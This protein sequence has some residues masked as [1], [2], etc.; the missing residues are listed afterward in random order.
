M[1]TWAPEKATGPVGTPSQSPKGEAD[2]PPAGDGNR[3]PPTD[4]VSG[5]RH[6]A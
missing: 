2:A 4:P 5:G 3:T 1:G 6:V